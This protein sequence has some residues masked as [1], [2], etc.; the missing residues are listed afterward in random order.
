MAYGYPD[1][2]LSELI[3][4]NNTPSSDSFLNAIRGLA[5]SVGN[6]YVSRKK[7]DRLNAIE[8][9]KEL[10][11]LLKSVYAEGGNVV[12]PS[13]S[14][15]P[16][17]S[18]ENAQLPVFAPKVGIETPPMATNPG[19]SIGQPSSEQISVP[20]QKTV[21][22]PQSTPER[23]LPFMNVLSEDIPSNAQ[24]RPNAINQ[25]LKRA[26]A[27]NT[28]ALPAQRAIAEQRKTY[29]FNINNEN[30]DRIYNLAVA[31]YNLTKQHY[32]DIASRSTTDKTFSLLKA[33]SDARF[34]KYTEY[35]ALRSG[36]PNWNPDT[37]TKLYNE[38]SA[39]D[40]DL[41]NY[42]S[43]NTSGEIQS[44]DQQPALGW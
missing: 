24:I 4:A 15:F 37:L 34:K 10:I 36:A 26:M 3:A 1:V 27:I 9:R 39:A 29:Q 13:Q 14:L 40:E 30:K 25:E 19:L 28:A 42:I 35:N 41:L 11:N 21:V 20:Y 32:R 33:E 22:T 12:S 17:V 5:S 31:R 43:A 6:E 16:S 38:W 8:N 44:S 2:T 23:E 7:E 18:H